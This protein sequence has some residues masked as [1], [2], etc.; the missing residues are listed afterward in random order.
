MVR[1][2]SPSRLLV[3]R[4]IPNHQVH[5]REDGRLAAPGQVH[6]PALEQD[7]SRLV[8]AG[9]R[10]RNSITFNEYLVRRK[11]NQLNWKLC[12][13]GFQEGIRGSILAGVRG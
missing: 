1:C 4:H 9:S 11:T 13:I 5:R 12:V 7:L 6:A 10:R 2:S 3:Q 8:P